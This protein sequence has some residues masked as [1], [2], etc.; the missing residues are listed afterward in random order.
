M[1]NLDEVYLEQLSAIAGA[2]QNSPLLAEYLENEE[3]EYYNALRQEFEQMIGE[4]YHQVAID[5][6]LQLTIFERYLLNEAFEGLYMPRIL[7]FAV[8]RGEI[9]DQYRYVRPNE[10]FKEILLAICHSPHFELL[11]KRIGQTIQ[12]GFALSS[13]IWIS[14]LL[15]LIENRRVRYFLQQQ[16]SD[17]YHDLKAREALYKRYANQ[18]KGNLFI[19]ADFPETPGEMKAGFSALRQFLLQRFAAGVDNTSLKPQLFN[20]L[21]N[22]EFSGHEEYVQMLA[23]CGQFIELDNAEQ[24]RYKAHFERERK[25]YPQ[26][27]RVFLQY[28]LTINESFPIKP[29]HDLRMSRLVD[30]TVADKIS[31]YYKIADKIHTLGYVHP[32]AIEAVR[33]FYNS[34]KALSVESACLRALVYN[35]FHQ[36]IKG[37]QISEYPAFIELSQIFNLYI[38]IFGNQEFN[39]AV[40]DLSL[41]YTDSLLQH[42][43]DKRGRD[44]QDIKKFMFNQF[45]EMGFL[46]EKELSEKFKTKRKVKKEA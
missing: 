9:N 26:F 24:A 2:I 43:T 32:E 15:S 19:S 28:L 38:K 23:L 5:A 45:V 35:Y 17:K 36:L 34:H 30:K 25:T 20:F 10:H 22:P 18:F 31:D 8:L 7:G 33:E 40:E 16:H 11:K 44:Y 46:S 4:L 3:E 14:N 42:F 41:E 27:D 12:V 39:Q 21:D 1:Q 37:L 29:E 6:P 13:D